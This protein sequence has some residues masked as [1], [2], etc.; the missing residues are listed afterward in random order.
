M[1]TFILIHGGFHGGWCWERVVALLDAAGHTVI[2]PDLP[3]MGDDPTPHDRITLASTADFVASLAQKQP[4]P[5][6]LAGHSMGGLVVGEVA[7]RIPEKI[8]GLVYI[9]AVLILQAMTTQQG[10]Q[11]S[12][13][14]AMTP[15]ANGH[16]MIYDP[17]MAAEIF[18]NKTDAVSLA[19]AVSRLR[20]Q[21]I[22]P[23][24]GPVTASESRFGRVPR[25]FIECAEDR[26]IPLAV[27]RQMQA[28]L[29][30]DP[31]FTLESDHS[32]FLSAPRELVDCLLAAGARFGSR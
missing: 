14:H 32:P 13:R 10:A 31:V 3:G 19:S 9:T 1:T 22:A 28:A 18:Y 26:A 30:C 4:G 25:A 15:T 8:Q 20:P 12:T 27:Q 11:L 16:S 24:K 7:E 5:V 23:M 21:P 17:A 29:P 2:A 6:V